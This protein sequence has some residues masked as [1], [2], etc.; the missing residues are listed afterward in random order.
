M[1]KGQRQKNRKKWRWAEID[2][3]DLVAELAQVVGPKIESRG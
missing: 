2:K 3:S 1:G